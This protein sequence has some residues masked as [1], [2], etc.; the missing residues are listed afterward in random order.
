MTTR[1]Q[2]T[3]HAA[4]RLMRDG[5][6][7]AA[8]RALQQGLA[9]RDSGATFDEPSSIAPKDIEGRY[10]VVAEPPDERFATAS[11]LARAT[12]QATFVDARFTCESGSLAYKVFVPEGLAPEV[13]PPLLLMLHGCTQTPDD[14]ARGTRMNE[15]AQEHG[16]VVAYPAQAKGSNASRCWNWFRAQ[17]QQRDR[18]EG[19]LLAALARHLVAVHRLDA[20][21]VFAA[22]L[23]AGGAM[24]AVLAHTHPEV[25]A[26][27]GVHSG[28]PYGSA[29]DLPSALTAM[30]AGGSGHSGR[31]AASRAIVFHGDADGTVN[32]RNGDGLAAQF[33]C[34]RED[35]RLSVER[36]TTT[37][38]RAFTRRVYHDAA[39]HAALEHWTIHGAGHAWSGGAAGGSYTDPAGPD[40]SLAMI[41]FFSAS[42][43]A[44]VS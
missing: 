10:H 16:Y 39:G 30:K 6:L 22:G 34:A 41:R 17:D 5:N 26:A 4:M 8:T 13:R 9:A 38:G 33:A 19:A 14:F 21:R 3:M 44:A 36:E 43:N 37:R 24:A 28:L 25:F 12:S 2:H 1:M 18:G 40:A 27:V 20:E 32:V 15:I 7:A 23:S 31:I 42:A 11:Q 35:L 29:H